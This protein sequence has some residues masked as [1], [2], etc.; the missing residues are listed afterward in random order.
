M[1]TLF[2]HDLMY[3]LMQYSRH[4][5]IVLSEGKCGPWQKL[6]LVCCHSLARLCWG[7]SAAADLG[8]SQWDY[9]KGSG[10]DPLRPYRSGL[11]YWRA[12]RSGGE[13]RL[14]FPARCAWL[15]SS[16][17]TLG[18]WLAWLAADGKG[19]WKWGRHRGTDSEVAL[20]SLESE[21]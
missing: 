15:S 2:E 12:E 18:M 10:F 9:S 13:I 7:D 16:W 3:H 5:T 4:L 6:Q 14:H 19:N 1:R 11:D 17:S 20:Y 8:R 21:I